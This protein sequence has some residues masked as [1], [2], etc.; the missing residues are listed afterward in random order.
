MKDR[1]AL[2]KAARALLNRK[3]APGSF[4]AAEALYE[5]AGPGSVL[6]IIGPFMALADSAGRLFK[7]PEPA[8]V[9]DVLGKEARSEC[10]MT[11][12]GARNTKEWKEFC[13]RC[14]HTSPNARRWP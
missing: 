9:S 2:L 12:F 5:A 3:H 14:L 1:V 10:S 8:V 4:G 6:R 13:L 7:E 11:R